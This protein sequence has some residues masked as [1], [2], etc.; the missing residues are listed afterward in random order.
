MHRGRAPLRHNQDVFRRAN[1]RL[2]AAVGDRIDHARPIPFLCECL[3]PACRSTVQL[4]I[5]QFQELRER[6][7][8]FAIV[9]GHPTMDDERIV[10]VDGDV[11]VVEKAA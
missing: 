10:A 6:R 1:E 11:T 2:L 7:N 4:T 8:L 5:E 9:T 3:D